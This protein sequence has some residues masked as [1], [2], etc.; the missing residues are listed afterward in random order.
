MS[1]CRWDLVQ[2]NSRVASDVFYLIL[3]TISLFIWFWRP[4]LFFWWQCLFRCRQ[5]S[6]GL[7]ITCANLRDS[8]SLESV[9]SVR[10]TLPLAVHRWYCHLW[11]LPYQGVYKV[12]SRKKSQDFAPKILWSIYS[13]VFFEFLFKISYSQN[14]KMIRFTYIVILNHNA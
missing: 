10:M 12:S 1:P 2:A 11:L 13:I 3:M 9:S 5:K 8:H 4:C 6:V 7:D 14:A